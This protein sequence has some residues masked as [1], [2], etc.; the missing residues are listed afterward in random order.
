MKRVELSGKVISGRGEAEKFLELRWVK[1]QV[2]EK[3][4]FTPYNGTLNVRLSQGSAKHRKTLEKE[5]SIK[6]CPAEGYCSA[7]IFKAF[8][9]DLT[10]AVLIPEVAGY[11]AD[12]LEIV[13]PT[14]LREKLQLLDG[15]E[16]TVVINL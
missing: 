2:E 13:A 3:L 12:V 8:I 11:P 7:R 5:V 4:G 14:N 16:V 1:Q 15:D 10:C 6:V 9:N